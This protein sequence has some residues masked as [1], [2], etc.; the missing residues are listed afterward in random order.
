MSAMAGYPTAY[1]SLAVVYD[2]GHYESG[3]TWA[4]P[5]GPKIIPAS[6]AATAQM[7]AISTT[8]AS[9]PTVHIVNASSSL[10][11]GNEWQ[12]NA[13]PT[14]YIGASHDPFRVTI[15]VCAGSP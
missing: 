15:D 4:G 9:S 5:P 11:T 12:V 3:A 14:D 7:K 13:G 6:K 2:E 8:P 10:A 1:V